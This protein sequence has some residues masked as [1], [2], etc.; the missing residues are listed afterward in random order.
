[1]SELTDA[2]LAEWLLLIATIS[3]RSGGNPHL[4]EEDRANLRQAASRLSSRGEINELIVEATAEAICNAMSTLEWGLRTDSERA[5][6][7]Q[8]ARAAL[9]GKT[10][11]RVEQPNP[12]DEVLEQCKA[13]YCIYPR[14]NCETPEE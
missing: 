12:P 2:Q 14:C 5:R 9:A 8:G 6:F 1:M 4:N 10:P 11:E 3:D 13:D 7:R